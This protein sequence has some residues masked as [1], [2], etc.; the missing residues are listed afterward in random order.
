MASLLTVP[1]YLTAM[2]FPMV[3]FCQPV[4]NLR[5]L[6][7]PLDE[8]IKWGFTT[9]IQFYI[10]AR[11]HIGAWKALKGGRQAPSLGLTRNQA[12][13]QQASLQSLKVDKESCSPDRPADI[14][15]WVVHALIATSWTPMRQVFQSGQWRAA[16]EAVVSRTNRPR[17]GPTWTCWSRWAPTPATSTP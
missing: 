6:G 2:V 3:P 10:G 11:F 13:L 9:P 16:T 4:L 14:V 17:T 15:A 12:G 1:V 8:L 5:V 7:F